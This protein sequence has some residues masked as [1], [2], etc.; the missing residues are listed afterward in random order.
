MVAEPRPSSHSRSVR[1]GPLYMIVASL[2]LTVMIAAVKVAREELGTFDVM[3][4]RCATAMPLAWWLT[5]RGGA[6]LRVRN[7]RLMAVRC[8]LGFAAMACFFT[9]TYGLALADVSILFKLQPIFVAGLAPLF[10]GRAERPTRRI[11]VVIA[12]GLGGCA[13]IVGPGLAVG[14]VYGLWALGAAA[15]GAGAHVALR[16]LGPTDHPSTIVFWYQASSLVLSVIGVGVVTGGLPA[17]PSAGLW[18]WL[19]VIG[20]SATLGQLVM[21]HAYRIEKASTVAAAS[22]VGPVWAA[23]G[24]LILFGAL[25]SGW[26]LGGGALVV[27]AGLLLVFA[28][29]PKIANEA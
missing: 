11:F 8:G 1:R 14:N 3:V 7:V 16:G 10:L 20:V 19:I 12:L 4:W 29:R 17:L 23:A 15:L 13:L 25:P 27:G 24:D 9:A 18:P 21:S 28:P 5:R 22:Y 6:G 2:L 26:A